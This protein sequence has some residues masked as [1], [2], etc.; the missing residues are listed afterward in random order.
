MT[1]CTRLIAATACVAL[2]A[3]ACSSG[4]GETVSADS[5][6]PSTVDPASVAASAPTTSESPPVTLPD[7]S[8]EASLLPQAANDASLPDIVPESAVGA[9][10]FSRYVYQD[11]AGEL[12]PTL[13]EGPQG[14]Q[15]RCQ[16]LD[17][18][19]SF[20]ELQALYDSGEELPDY[21][22]MDRETLGALLDQL[23]RV[24]AAVTQYDDLDAACAAGMMVSSTQN[25]NMGIHVVDPGAGSDFDPDRPQMILF[26][27]EGGEFIPRSELGQCRDG[28]FS[29]E[30]GFR[31]VGAVF[32][33]T[34]S[35]DHPD[36]FAGEL[37]NWHIHLNTCGGSELENADVIDAE[38]E[39]AEAGVPMSR[40]ECEASG[41]FFIPVVSSWMMHAYVVPE[42]D[43]QGGV[44]SM[45]N[46]NI[47][48]L[49]E[50]P[51]QL[52]EQET[53]AA[54]DSVVPAPIVNFDYGDIDAE[55]GEP[56]VFANADSVPHTV[57][58]GSALDPTSDFDSGVLGTGQTFELSFDQAGEY[59]LFC[60]L[61]PEMQTTVSVS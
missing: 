18:Q 38:A 45:Y 23:A 46:P 25:A 12:V 52:R 58:S 29:G 8:A 6:P 22:E 27:K 55:V 20:T 47:W 19:C 31:P 61:H 32:N 4:S 60:V 3:A 43:P 53:V 36:A 15:V 54:D 56:I 51:E 37:D 2:I 34:M 1:Q 14:R 59:P 17:R 39:A 9:Y 50:S 30:D 28:E 13:I 41:G 48:P 10:G 7:Y 35:E 44:F 40:E 11:Q 33:V 5:T 42:Y 16:Q 57:T 26:A 21:L 24:N 49:A